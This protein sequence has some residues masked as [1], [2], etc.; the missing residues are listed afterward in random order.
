M[1]PIHQIELPICQ[2]FF[3][4]FFVLFSSYHSICNFAFRPLLHLVCNVSGT[5]TYGFCMCSCKTSTHLFFGCH[6]GWVQVP[7]CNGFHINTDLMSVLSQPH[8]YHFVWNWS[9]FESLQDLFVSNMIQLCDLQWPSDHSYF[10]CVQ[11]LVVF[12]HFWPAFYLTEYITVYSYIPDKRIYISVYL[13][14]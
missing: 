10:Y 2:I 11:C 13:C 7:P 12:L 9:N 14:R 6:L 3:F 1:N 8:F 5:Y 4:F